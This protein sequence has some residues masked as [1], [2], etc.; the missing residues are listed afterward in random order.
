MLPV[1]INCNLLITPTWPH[2]ISV[3]IFFF[4]IKSS[5][6][7]GKG[8]IIQGINSSAPAVVGLD[9]QGPFYKVN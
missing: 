7:S 6:Y 1:S 2:P 8:G 3:R 9:W 5:A 4:L